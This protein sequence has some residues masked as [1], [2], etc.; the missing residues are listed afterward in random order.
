MKLERLNR[1]HWALAAIVIGV[2]LAQ[3]QLHWVTRDPLTAGNFID[4]PQRF[5]SWLL[6][7][8]N[9]QP[10]LRDIVV[11][12]TR[13]S[14][15]KQP[16]R[17]VVTA[18]RVYDDGGAVTLVPITFIP[19]QPYKPQ[20][21]FDYLPGPVAADAVK[22]LNANANPSFL[23]YLS[24][25]QTA[26][27]VRY[28]YAWW[29]EPWRATAVWVAASLLLIAGL[30]PTLINLIVFH[31]LTRPPQEKGIDLSK[32]RQ[33][34]P[35]HTA[36]EP[37]NSTLEELEREMETRLAIHPAT[38]LEPLTSPEAAP[39]RTLRAVEDEP[40]AIEAG[41]DA[42]EFGAKPDD[43]YPTAKRHCGMEER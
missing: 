42:T 32:V 40:V 21:S 17:Y 13:I 14:G 4:D 1:W 41:G 35:S 20:L 7:Q 26:A 12:P 15:D 18:K 31:R 30:W 37:D 36:P 9:G 33:T 8:T 5:E 25:V 22:K 11:H 28:R 6:R 19:P 24:A 16:V 2:M 10:W 29:E 23:D 34:R 43:Y 39:V 3:A 38:A 27:G